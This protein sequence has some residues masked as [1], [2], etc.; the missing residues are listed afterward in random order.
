MKKILILLVGVFMFVLTGCD[1][2]LF[3]NNG[4][5]YD[6]LY[7]VNNTIV[8]YFSENSILDYDNYS[9]NYVDDKNKVVVVGL[10]DNS[11]KS[12][13]E[14]KRKV[15]DSELIRFEQGERMV[16][17]PLIGGNDEDW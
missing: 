15:I 6:D 14:F 13:E 2:V 10:L 7:E 3:Y 9:Y 16:N 5:S 11:I 12:Q 17:Q 4:V 8:S 1:S